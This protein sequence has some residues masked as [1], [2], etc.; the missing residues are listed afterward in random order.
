M[1]CKPNMARIYLK[2]HVECRDSVFDG[3]ING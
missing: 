3:Y 1:E 2:S